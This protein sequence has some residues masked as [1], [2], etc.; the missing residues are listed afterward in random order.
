MDSSDLGPQDPASLEDGTF[1]FRYRSPQAAAEYPA[2]SAESVSFY[3]L[4]KEIADSFK[5]KREEM[6]YS[7]DDLDGECSLSVPGD[8]I[9]TVEQYEQDASVLTPLVISLV[10]MV[11][12]VNLSEI[13]P[14]CLDLEKIE[15]ETPLITHYL[16]SHNLGLQAATGGKNTD[17]VPLQSQVKHFIAIRAL[18]ELE[19]ALTHTS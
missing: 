4:Q 1:Y 7:P 9:V 12:D 6:G 17:L 18:H 8:D 2:D 16:E 5:A 15:R 14:S 19:E 13:I 3:P 10:S 11:L